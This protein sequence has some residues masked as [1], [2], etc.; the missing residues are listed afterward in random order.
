MFR[1]IQSSIFSY[2]FTI[3]IIAL[4]FLIV[5]INTI[6]T[7][8]EKKAVESRL[9]VVAL[10]ISDFIKTN[11]SEKEAAAV[12][13]SQTITDKELNGLKKQLLKVKDDIV[14][15]KAYQKNYDRN[16]AQFGK[17]NN[18]KFDAKALSKL[19]EDSELDK[20]A[21]LYQLWLNDKRNE[22][23]VAYWKFYKLNNTLQKFNKILN[24]KE[25]YIIDTADGKVIASSTNFVEIGQSFFSTL[26]TTKDGDKLVRM[27]AEGKRNHYWID[28]SPSK[29]N[30][31][32]LRGYL[33]TKT[34]ATGKYVIAYS[35]SPGDWEMMS[36]IAS[37]N[38]DI[39]L[40]GSD[41]RIR[42]T[43]R[44][45][46]ENPS[47]V[48]LRMSQ[49][50][51]SLDDLEVAKKNNSVIGLQKVDS[52]LWRNL[53]KENK[54]LEVSSVNGINALVDVVALKRAGL[55]WSIVV[56]WDRDI[57]YYE[58][59]TLRIYVNALLAI[60]AAFFLL[61]VIYGGRKLAKPIYALKRAL[62]D[63]VDQPLTFLAKSHQNSGITDDMLQKLE[64]ISEE[65]K[66]LMSDKEHLQKQ[67]E[68]LAGQME[69]STKTIA[70]Q[71]E[72][73]KKLH[74]IKDEQHKVIEKQEHQLDDELKSVK[75]VLRTPLF[76]NTMFNSSVEEFF[77][78]HSAKND[79]SGDFIWYHERDSRVFFFLGDTGKS[80]IDAALL[81]MILTSLINETVKVKKISSPD[82]ILESLNKSLLEITK[83]G[84]K[85][86]DSAVNLSI[87]VWD[88]QK[89]MMEF[90]GANHSIFVVRDDVLDELN[91][92]AYGIGGLG[93]DTTLKY[94]THYLPLNRIKQ[95]RLYLFSDGFMK[96]KNV[97]NEMFTHERF[98]ELLIDMQIESIENQK[99]YINR[100]YMEWKG[101]GIQDD[102]TTI[103]GLKIL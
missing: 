96:Q 71:T 43:S 45:F 82:R 94:N 7:K 8:T 61:G 37:N 13:L 18:G 93:A 58:W 34:S 50:G 15:P 31:G 85:V 51:Y 25:A 26:F 98:K 54:I 60:I 14:A 27:L 59:D 6:I 16:Y 36:P 17:I 68:D 3:V 23:D 28:V 57:A 30:L 91:G 11:F 12:S 44:E 19:M 1:K 21:Y 80:D 38:T 69:V 64:I 92:D 72:E 24:A 2:F 73:Q 86:F 49:E 10:A 35:Y 4:F 70:H 29:L 53:G 47:A 41:G 87:C 81:R 78:I 65:V 89:Q 99:D 5:V 77:H 95:C 39:Y 22:K 32:K 83:K 46:K 101:D 102:D 62:E 56:E 48:L 90:A 88:R 76:D 97:E 40:V 74:G 33:L 84:D 20:S 66:T 79:I 52:T 63:L 103:L 67:L 9:E 75:R 42:T 55:D 100:T